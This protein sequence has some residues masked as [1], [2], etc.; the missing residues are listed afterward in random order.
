MSHVRWSPGEQIVWT[1]SLRG[2]LW[3]QRPVTVVRHD[4]D[5][6]LGW[7]APGTVCRF[8]KQPDDLEPGDERGMWIVHLRARGGWELTDHVWRGGGA[9]MLVRDGVGHAVWALLNE[10]GSLAQWYLNIQ[11]EPT[12]NTGGFDAMD[13]LLDVEVEPDLSGWSL[14]DEDHLEE[15]VRV[16]LYTRAQADAFHAE[17]VRAV[18]SIIAHGP[19]FVPIGPT[20]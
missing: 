3:A 12:W 19:P 6:L 1:E 10:D 4:D 11:D 18:G 14:K 2:R 20:R 5:G 15:A 17:A 16:G 7:M 8:K 9:L 13:H